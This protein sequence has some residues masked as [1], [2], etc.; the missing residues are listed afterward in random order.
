MGSDGCCYNIFSKEEMK[1]I[2][3]ALLVEAQVVDLSKKQKDL[4]LRIRKKIKKELK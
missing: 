3:E 4:R 1:A 2:K